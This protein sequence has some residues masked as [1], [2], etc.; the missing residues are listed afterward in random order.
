[1]SISTLSLFNEDNRALTS[2][3]ICFKEA[4]YEIFSFA[5]IS[6]ASNPSFS[7]SIPLNV[8]D[9]FGGEKILLSCDAGIDLV[10]K[11]P[12]PGIITQSCLCKSSIMC[13]EIDI[14]QI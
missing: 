11:A 12:N 3:L 13:L 9:F 5:L 7:F 8:T 14:N 1:M 6:F 10:K 2:F 4:L